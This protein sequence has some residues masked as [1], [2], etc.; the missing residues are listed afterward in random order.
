LAKRA[1]IIIIIIINNII[2]VQVDLNT[3]RTPK[4]LFSSSPSVS[5]GGAELP[6]A[7]RFASGSSPIAHAHAPTAPFTHS[8]TRGR[9]SAPILSKREKKQT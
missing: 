6:H 7:N 8:F 5:A 2:S 1:L 9:N 3:S 4:S